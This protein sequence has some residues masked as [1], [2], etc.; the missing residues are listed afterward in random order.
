MIVWTF[1]D[2]QRISSRV[3]DAGARAC[4]HKLRRED[5]VAE[6]ARL[7]VVGISEEAWR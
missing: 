6:L 5:L 7:G 4:V 3:R 2:D 1:H